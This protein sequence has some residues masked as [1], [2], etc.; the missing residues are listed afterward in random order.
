MELFN[1]SWSG[2]KNLIRKGIP[3]LLEA[4]YILK[5]EGLNIKLTLAG[6]N[7][8]GTEYLYDL[9]NKYNL[10]SS[11]NILGEINKDEKINLMSKLA[12][13]VQPSHYEGFGLA[14]AEAMACGACI[15]TCDVGAVKDVVSDCGLYANPGSAIDL[16]KKIRIAIENDR[17][18]NK[19]QNMA[20]KRANSEFSYKKKLIMLNDI[21]SEL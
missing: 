7:G 11:V 14:M 17:L 4:L 18:R 6:K 19:L 8:D 13:F 5:N 12:I 16:A 21:L 10:N 15:I 2:K 20:Y 9:L 1:I 3:E